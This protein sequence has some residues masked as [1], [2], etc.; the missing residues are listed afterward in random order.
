MTT[1]DPT[2]LAE[3]IAREHYRTVDNLGYP[4]GLRARCTCGHT[5]TH[6][7]DEHPAH[8]ATVT[9]QA[10]LREAAQWLA[11]TD[12]PDGWHTGARV[13]DALWEAFVDVVHEDEDGHWHGRELTRE[14]VA[15]WMAEEAGRVARGATAKSA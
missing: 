15:E 2:P 6:P 13:P 14:E 12:Y 8:I 3:Q 5:Y 1:T 10:V 4:E 7:A 11:A 9:E